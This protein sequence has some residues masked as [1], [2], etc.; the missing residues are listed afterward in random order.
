MS[1]CESDSQHGCLSNRAR[2]PRTGQ[3]SSEPSLRLTLVRSQPRGF[4]APNK[5]IG[6]AAMSMRCCAF[7]FELAGMSRHPPYNLQIAAESHAHIYGCCDTCMSP[8]R[9]PVRSLG[10]QVLRTDTGIGAH[11]LQNACIV[12]S[13][14][15][16]CCTGTEA[17]T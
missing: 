6:L 3:Q 17:I 9:S 11:M 4:D 8:V 5:E 12:S 16:M 13:S 10:P 1:V 2:K 15:R 7:F 14:G